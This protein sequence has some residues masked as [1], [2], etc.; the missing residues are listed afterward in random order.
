MRWEAKLKIKELL[1]LKVYPFTFKRPEMNIVEFANS[2]DQHQ[3]APSICFP[4]DI[5]NIN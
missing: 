3:A 5:F 1:S 4:D 2:A